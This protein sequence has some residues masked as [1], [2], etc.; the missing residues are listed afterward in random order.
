MLELI[1]FLLFNF[2]QVKGRYCILFRTFVVVL[3]WLTWKTYIYIYIILHI[4]IEQIIFN[5]SDWILTCNLFH[6]PDKKEEHL[7]SRLKWFILWIYI[8]QVNQ[9]KKK[10]TNVLI[11][12]SIF[13]PGKVNEIKWELFV[14]LS[15]TIQSFIFYYSIICKTVTVNRDQSENSPRSVLSFNKYVHRW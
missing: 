4:L 7:M 9:R 3:F 13:Y 6:L 15:F 11:Y 10:P 2:N 12:I 8:F 14:H 5:F 1:T